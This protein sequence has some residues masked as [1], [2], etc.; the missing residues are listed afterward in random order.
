MTDK[1]VT[2]EELQKL[3]D[4][5]AQFEA[6]TKKYGELRYELVTLQLAMQEID[7][8]FAQLDSTR[9]SLVQTL[10]ERFQAPG[11]ISLETGE[12][13]PTVPTSSA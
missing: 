7:N 5:Q 9:R 11:T 6:L 10:E 4:L 3:K 1:K 12:F 13:V 8:A 2:P